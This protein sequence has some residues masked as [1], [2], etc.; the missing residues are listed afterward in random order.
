MRRYLTLLGPVA[1]CHSTKGCRISRIVLHVIIFRMESYAY[2]V[3]ENRFTREDNLRGTKKQNQCID[4]PN[5]FGK[6]EH[7]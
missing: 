2:D 3:C 6:A 1:N 5:A 4:C 7:L